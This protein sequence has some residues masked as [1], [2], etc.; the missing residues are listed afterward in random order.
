MMSA[1]KFQRL[2]CL[3][4]IVTLCGV[5]AFAAEEQR[6]K[7]LVVMSYDPAYPLVQEMIEGIA[8]V[9]SE[10]CDLTYFYLDTKQHFDDGPAKAAEANALYQQ[11]Q[12]DGV[13]VG[14]DDAQSMFVVPYLKDK[15][16]TPVMFLGVNAAP[17][18]YGYPAT[19]VS[20]ILERLHVQETLTFLRQLVPSV[21]T[22]GF[23]VKESP[24]GRT[25]LAQM[26]SELAIYP[27]QLAASRFPTTTAEAIQF[28]ESLRETCDALYLETM[29]G[30]LDQAG[31]PITS[32]DDI[33]P[34]LVKTFGKPTAG[35]NLY[36]V[37]NGILCAVVKSGQ[38][39]GEV[40]SAMLLQA[41]RGTPV[42]QLPITRNKRGKRLLN[43][44][45]MKALGIKPKP[46][47]LQGVEFI[48]T[49]E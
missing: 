15:V 24:V 14:D 9:L 18:Q 42:A 17:E 11:L 7:V 41:M 34:L 10:T 39:Q 46:N 8:T 40:A 23:M 37:K 16:R 33:F 25:V 12:P 29:L 22:F 5:T 19:N 36:H 49:T 45:T 32:D 35:A 20:G 43:V 4:C 21:R 28:A 30:L 27:M 48:N 3:L 47:V 31:Q 38:E 44:T 26:E 2:V 1:K 6:F 13:L